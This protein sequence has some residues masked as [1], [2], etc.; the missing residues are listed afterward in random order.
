MLLQWYY[1]E[2]STVVVYVDICYWNLV[3][4][5]LFL[6]YASFLGHRRP[7]NAVG[8]L[9]PLFRSD[10]EILGSLLRHCN[11]H[12]QKSK[13]DSIWWVLWCCPLSLC[14]LNQYMSLIFSRC[15]KLP[16]E[17]SWGDIG[18]CTRG[19]RR[20]LRQAV[21][22]RGLFLEKP[23]RQN[24]IWPNGVDL[25]WVGADKPTW[26]LRSSHAAFVLLSEG[27]QSYVGRNTAHY[28]FFAICPGS[29]VPES[30]MLVRR[31]NW[32]ARTLPAF[33]CR[34][35]Q[36]HLGC[37]CGRTSTTET[38]DSPQLFVAVMPRYEREVCCACPCP[39]QRVERVVSFSVRRT[40]EQQ[41]SSFIKL[42][43]F[44]VKWRAPC[45][46]ARRQ[47]AN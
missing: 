39:I 44:F 47:A 18:A 23:V 42:A 2:A 31:T 12:I 11:L 22:R 27:I 20:F 41:Q 16:R 33:P 45:E 37:G 30:S 35:W 26:S 40:T 24:K 32:S 15:E 10:H 34:R 9:Q 13:K 46:G 1:I 6:W 29:P 36:V 25:S 14:R 7:V 21:P 5:A 3:T 17:F 8:S 28:A 38:T 19:F 43:A 4:Y